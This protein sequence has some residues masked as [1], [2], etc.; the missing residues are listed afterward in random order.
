MKFI[1]SLLATVAVLA[2]AAPLPA[3]AQQAQS[4]KEFSLKGT[5]YLPQ[6]RRAYQNLRKSDTYETRKFRDYA[7]GPRA[8]GEPF[9]NGFFFETPSGPFGGYTPYMH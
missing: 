7:F 8:Q 3:A 9:D 4:K 5:S 2:L 1:F 6:R